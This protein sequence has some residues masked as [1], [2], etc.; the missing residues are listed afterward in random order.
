MRTLLIGVSLVLATTAARAQEVT[1]ASLLAEMTD[2]ERLT[3]MPA[4]DYRTVQ[5]SSTD[6]RS[7]GIEEPG[8]FSNA[9][10]F[11]QE[12]IPGFRKVLKAPGADGVGEY[13]VCDVDGPGAI[14]R[15]W[16]AGMDGV[17]RVWLDGAD[18]PMF[19]GKGYDFFARRS[20]VLLPGLLAKSKLGPV[21]FQE[22]D[23]DY[24]PIPFE[25]HLRITWTGSVRD[26]HFY[27]LQVRFYA[28]GT[29][30]T[31]FAPGQRV[32]S[33]DELLRSDPLGEF[34]PKTA[35]Q[36]DHNIEIASGA[37]WTREKTTEQGEA[38]TF[39]CVALP[40]AERTRVLR[41]VLLRLYFDGS[42]RPQVEA[43]LGD[44]FGT[45]I[46]VNPFVSIPMVVD[47]GGSL[48]CRWPMPFR[49]SCRI[50]LL[51]W[52]ADKVQLALD[53]QYRTFTFDDHTL[54]FHALWRADHQ[55]FSRAAKAPIDLPYITAL[56]EGRFV[57]VACQIANPPMD[58]RWRSNW[59]GEGDEKIFVDGALDALGTGSE[60]Y[61]NYSWSHWQYFS[62]SYCGQP[63]CSGPG[64]CG[65]VSNHRLQILDD[66]PFHH[67]LQVALELWS[68]KP[69]T[70]LSYARTAYFYARPGVVTD[71][72]ALQPSDLVV[73]ALLPWQPTDF[74]P[75]ANAMAWR[76]T[77]AKASAGKTEQVADTFTRSGAILQ[78]TA[79]AGGVLEL[80]V[81][82]PQD[83][84]YLLRVCCQQ[85]PDAPAVQLRVD[86]EAKKNGDQAAFSLQ[87]VHGER[88]EDLVVDNVTLTKGAHTLA[89]ACP[90]GGV[91]GVDLVGFERHTDAA[92][93]LPGAVEGEVM[94]LV[95]ASP[96]VQAEV[97]A[98]GA[99]WSAGHHRWVRAGK[100]G[101]F[102]TF[103]V[104]APTPGR[105][106]A[107]LRL[108]RSW[109]YGIL[110]VDWNGETLQ[111]DV[112]TF[113]GED[114]KMSVVDID[115]G[116]R[117]L[118]KPA[119]LTLTVTGSNPKAAKPGS[120]FGVDCVV[121]KK[122]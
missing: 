21:M 66:L 13:E 55:L 11:G 70:P 87:C 50:E 44:F 116:E 41:G 23:G 53:L 3:R 88:F 58:P 49:R 90:K 26:L 80:P 95:A 4:P 105:Y 19:E 51:N 101:D 74:V 29:K 109:D 76:A 112:D 15:G 96:G 27:H 106:R 68:H 73:P 47:A 115:L 34:W 81:E 114:R 20:N 60:D 86:G 33:P 56:G 117:D 77:A 94:D 6:R 110:R 102:A 119:E 91:I 16:S 45:G 100:V 22:Q 54:Y 111:R 92:K 7:T 122:L 120:Y 35:G 79:P 107:T 83:G 36:L 40:P 14:V 98:M 103:R 5:F 8:W 78:W 31:T 71:H 99:D 97:Q 72:R 82:V 84:V 63:L 75:D 85:R 28:A 121:L 52:T 37:T 18:T 39:L 59:W 32:L 113:G 25:K 65:F 108:S 48:A 9:D 38:L 61:F 89:I 67:S 118:G 43:P 64:N 10:G 30:V 1:T 104:A 2:L 12:P 93:Q 46:G 24:T 69:V 42:Q 57:G 62:H 17:L